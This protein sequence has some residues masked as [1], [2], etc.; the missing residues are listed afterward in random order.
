M[1]HNL[2]HV[3]RGCY[4]GLSVNMQLSKEALLS[5]DGGL[6]VVG[7]NGQANFNQRRSVD[8]TIASPSGQELYNAPG[9]WKDFKFSVSTS[10]IGA[11]KLW[12]FPLT[13]AGTA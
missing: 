12:C 10:E 3:S 6:S 9:I 1:Q 7:V 11:Y 4:E 13:P 8:V 2:Y 5:V